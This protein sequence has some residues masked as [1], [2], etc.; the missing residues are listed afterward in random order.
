[1]AF[2][3]LPT[4]AGWP[5][6]LKDG[7]VSLGAVASG[8][9]DLVGPS[10][11]IEADR[12]V[13][14][15]AQRT[16]CSSGIDYDIASASYVHLTTL[17]GYISTEAIGLEAVWDSSAYLGVTSIRISITYQSSGL[18]DIN[19]LN[20]SST[21]P[22]VQV[23]PLTVPNYVQGAFIAK[24]EVLNSLVFGWHYGITLTEI[25]LTTI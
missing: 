17:A 19:V 10:G 8:S 5:Y 15:H 21:T 1:M 24:I 12:W 22:L 6:T 16:V 3:P 9:A 23:L 20:N 2:A 7:L 14:V 13:R 25:P 4:E 11:I 18:T